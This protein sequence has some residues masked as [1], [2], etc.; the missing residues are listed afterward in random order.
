MLSTTD[1]KLLEL[2]DK[3]TPVTKIIKSG[4]YSTTVY[5]KIK[6]YKEHGLIVKIKEKPITYDT[7]YKGAG[8]ILF[9][10]RYKELL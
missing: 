4:Y 10:R 5:A 2:I 1:L 8:L 7:N 3:A 9:L 6:K